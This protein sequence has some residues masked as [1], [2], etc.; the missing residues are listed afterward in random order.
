M[1]GMQVST[2]HGVKIYNLSSGKPSI[3]C[4]LFSCTMDCYVVQHPGVMLFNPV[5]LSTALY[6]DDGAPPIAA[7]SQRASGR[8]SHDAILASGLPYG[9]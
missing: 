7:D 1:S 9:C 3:M 5:R 4:Q 8:A 2:F 6:K